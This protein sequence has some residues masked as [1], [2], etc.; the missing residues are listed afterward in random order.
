MIAAMPPCLLCPPKLIR[1]SP[2]PP[3]PPPSRTAPAVT[4]WQIIFDRSMPG[5]GSHREERSLRSLLAPPPSANPPNPGFV[6]IN[7]RVKSE[8]SPASNFLRDLQ[9]FFIFL[10]FRVQNVKWTLDSDS[11]QPNRFYIGSFHHILKTALVFLKF[12]IFYFSIVRWARHFTSYPFHR[13]KILKNQNTA[14]E[15]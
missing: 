10:F 6:P 11:G 5:T 2:L 3:P 9:V 1:A 14:E 12:G 4:D 15:M 8:P 13:W 7:H